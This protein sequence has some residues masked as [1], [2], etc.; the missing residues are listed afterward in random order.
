MREWWDD[1]DEGTEPKSF[2]RNFKDHLL[3][4]ARHNSLTAAR[5][6]KL[7]EF[8]KMTAEEQE[9]IRWNKVKQMVNVAFTRSP[10]YK[11]LYLSFAQDNIHNIHYLFSELPI[12]SKQMVR[13]NVEQIPTAPTRFLKAAHTSGTTGTPLKVYRSA[14]SMLTEHAY[15]WHFRKSHGVDFGDAA[16]SLRGVLDNTTMYY[17]NRSENMLYLSSY[18]LSKKNI[19]VYVKMMRKLQPRAIFG[20]PSSLYN[21][22]T[23][24]KELGLGVRIPC[25]FTSSETVYDF[26]RH[27]LQEVFNGRVYDTYGNVERTIAYGQCEYGNYHDLPMYSLNEFVQNGVISTS[28]TNKAFPLIRYFVDDKFVLEDRICECGKPFNVQRIEGRTDDVIRCEDG[29]MIT[30]MSLSFKGIK[31]LEYAQII[32]KVMSRIQVNVVTND[33]FTSEDKKVLMYE[34]RKRLPDCLDIDI[35]QISPEQIVKASSGKFKLVV[36]ALS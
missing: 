17:Y 14:G 15:M 27:T 1:A 18:L 25:I 9:M 7:D 31:G 10:F 36:S 6:R 28:L 16:L 5:M 30:G 32:Q 4:L 19:P 12:V 22:A 20:F 11:K 2:I 29:S 24:I 34:L 35:V 13:Q 33:D 3:F 23:M 8:E 26:Q 21:M